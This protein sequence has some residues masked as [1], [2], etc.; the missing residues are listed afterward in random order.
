MRQCEIPATLLLA[1]SLLGAGKTEAAATILIWPIDPWLSVERHATELWIENQGN[2]TAT[3]QVRIVGW[4]QEGGYER[5]GAQQEVVASPPILSV[6]KGDKQLIRLITQ[7]PVPVGVEKAYRIIVDEIPEPN[8]T[9]K[10]QMGLRLQMRYSIPLF[11][12]GEGIKT[13]DKGENHARVDTGKL[14]WRVV[15]EAGKPMLE[16]SNRDAVHLRLSNVTLRQSGRTQTVAP[17]LLGYVLPGE[18]RRWPLPVGIAHPSGISAT[19]NARDAK[20]QSAPGD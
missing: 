11:V 7:A 12:Y 2:A 1:A 19:I 15:Q 20:W 3:M 18:H 6:A 17:G 10:P 5:Y 14:S 16:I 13:Y 8:D 9:S 4:R